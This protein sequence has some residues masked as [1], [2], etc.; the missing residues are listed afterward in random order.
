[1]QKLFIPV[2]L[3]S[4]RKGRY[5]E[6][7]ARFLF[8]ILSERTEVDT[9]L[10]DVRD[11]ALPVTTVKGEE[12][13]AWLEIADRADGFLI[14]SPEYNHGYPGELKILLDQGEDDYEN[15]PVGLCGVSS[16]GLGGA[17]LVESLLPVLRTLGFWVI[18]EAL[19]TS[20]VE[21][22][23][24]EGELQEESYRVKAH[25]FIDVLIDRTK[26]F[27]EMR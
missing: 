8:D 16:G 22:I 25:K 20:N 23:F 13:Q 7:V 9:K 19:Y 12:T 14:V 3:G 17:R 15:K 11:F 24:V 6:H 27:K 10:V 2:I 5:S 18:P 1:M 21:K 4:G 26:K